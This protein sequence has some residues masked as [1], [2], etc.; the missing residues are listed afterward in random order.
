M[1]YCASV[2]ENA[3]IVY[4]KTECWCLILE[5]ITYSVILY[6]NAPSLGK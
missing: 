5:R 6:K 4:Q 1:V 2:W 3:A